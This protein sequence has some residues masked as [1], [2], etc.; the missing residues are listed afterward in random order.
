M[1]DRPCPQF[2]RLAALAASCLLAATAPAGG[3]GAHPDADLV[4][5]QRLIG[6]AACSD[7]AQCQTLA[8]GASG[9]GGPAAYLAWSTLRSTAPA[10]Q[11]A[12]AP[13]AAWRPGTV[14]GEASVCRVLPDPGAHCVRGPRPASGVKQPP[15]PPLG[16]CRLREHRSDDVL[17]LK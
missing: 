10:L 2:N 13:L 4:A 5:L 1:N 11:A 15:G 16:T 6:D 12:A 17:P 7:D 9:C 14:R 8:V 3:A